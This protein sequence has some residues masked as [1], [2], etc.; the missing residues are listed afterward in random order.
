MSDLDRDQDG[1][2]SVTFSVA[3]AELV[4]AYSLSAQSRRWA[5][6]SIA[7]LAMAMVT[8]IVCA[9]VPVRLSALADTVLCV[10]I[11]GAVGGWI[12][13]SYRR[14]IIVPRKARRIYAQQA[15][16][17]QPV[18]LDWDR[19]GLQSRSSAGTSRI[20]WSDVFG[21]RQG[22]TAILF[23][24]SE[25]NFNFIPVRVLSSAQMASLLAMTRAAQVPAR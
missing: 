22:S 21:I 5:W 16:F 25:A 17:R 14:L 15:A 20:A 6:L 23:Y 7:V 3:E 9:M 13:R 18:T 1:Q 12:G 4:A 19:T 2:G 10:C 11:G 8:V 24:T